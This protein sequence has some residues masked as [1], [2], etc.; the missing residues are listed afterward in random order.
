MSRMEHRRLGTSTKMRFIRSLTSW[1]REEFRFDH[2]CQKS[3][4]DRTWPGEETIERTCNLRVNKSHA[5]Q[6][7][8]LLVNRKGGAAGI[9][10]AMFLY[11]ALSN[12][13]TFM[14]LNIGAHTATL[15]EC[16]SNVHTCTCMPNYIQVHV[17]VTTVYVHVHVQGVPESK[18]NV[19]KLA[20]SS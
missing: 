8:H 1:E 13:I 11:L 19:Y 6:C 16:A 7:N 5:I 15:Y 3:L 14:L 20:T 10:D 2:S 18:K 12:C 4:L 17:H 9:G